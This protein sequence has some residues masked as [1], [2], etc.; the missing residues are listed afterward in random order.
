MSNKIRGTPLLHSALLTYRAYASNTG[1][2]AT[3]RNTNWYRNKLAND[4]VF[5]IRHRERSRLAMIRYRAR[6]KA[7][8]QEDQQ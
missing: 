4:P 3:K 8:V 2:K 5:L 6:L 7:M 1:E